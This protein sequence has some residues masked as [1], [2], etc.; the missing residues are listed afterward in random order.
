MN[1]LKKERKRL[2]ITQAEAAER[3]GISYSMYSQME[4]GF[5]D[6]S[7]STM[8]KVSKLYQKSVDYLFFDSPATES[9]RKAMIK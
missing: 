7:M 4:S 2:G 6:P 9:E 3:S 1:N 5:K 8:K